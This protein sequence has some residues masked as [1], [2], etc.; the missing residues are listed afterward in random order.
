MKVMDWLLLGFMIFYIILIVIAL[1]QILND[2]SNN[3]R[4]KKIKRK[5]DTAIKGT[6]ST[7]Y[8]TKDYEQCIFELNLVFN[9][10][11]LINDRLKSEYDNVAIILE[12]HIIDVNAGLVAIQDMDINLYKKVIFN[13][14]KE[15]NSRNPLEQI[16]GSDYV[17]LKQVLECIDTKNID[18]GKEIVNQLALQL[19]SLQDSNMEKEKNSRKQD[20]MAKWGIALSI[21]FGIMT[22]VQFFI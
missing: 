9:N 13:L 17:V 14:L 3:A 8:N 21:V 10:I 11:V 18:K 2:I 20:A 5:Y 15:Y 4:Y 7:Y 12:K 19:K 22:F 6:L 16:K 1:I